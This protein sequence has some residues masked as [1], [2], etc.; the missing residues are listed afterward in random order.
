MPPIIIAEHLSKRYRL[1]ALRRHNSLRDVFDEKLERL[2]G[3]AGLR[4]GAEEN[5]VWALNDVS[6]EVKK[7]EVLG[8]IGRNG[9]GKSTLLKILTRITEPTNGSVR[10]RGRVASLLEVGTGFSGELSGRE[11]IFL[12]GAI[13]GMSKGEIKRKFDEIVAFAEI[14]KF[15]DTPVKKYSSGM[16]MRLAFA[17]AA[18]LEPEILLIDEVLA[19][20]DIAFQ[21][22]CLGKMD[23]VGKQ[24]RTVIFV[25]HNMG[26][27]KQ[28][29][30][31][32]I[33]LSKGLVV[34]DDS[35]A[36]AI[37]FYM[38]E[39][40]KNSA[41][42]SEYNHSK[43][44]G[45]ALVR[46]LTINGKSRTES[47][48]AIFEQITIAITYEI[49]RPVDSLEFFLLIYSEDGEV[50]ANILQRDVG[51][52]VHPHG[53]S[54]AINVSFKNT[55]KPGKYFIS[56]GIFDDVKEFVDWVE[57]AETFTV[58]HIFSDGRNY[59][60]RLGNISLTAEWEEQQ[61]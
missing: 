26:V 53:K 30:P 13:L 15:I 3:K 9:A 60:H 40:M 7:G 46:I 23:E 36:A 57:Y 43:G 55:L 12:N 18:H 34:C 6:F 51:K 45:R 25:S 29:C 21:K 48:V 35:S 50:Q 16:Y 44:D 5:I 37:S 32:V 42:E 22:K 19:V 20:G 41:N 39:F 8:V 59:D 10:M 49:I 58:D 47:L 17:V 1:G 31:R 14:E 27:I 33:V 28:L 52:V 4:Q 11:N 54:G 38:Q 2:L 61:P 24:G 56:A